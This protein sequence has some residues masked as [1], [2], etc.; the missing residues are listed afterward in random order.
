MISVCCARM[1]TS[2][3]FPSSPHC[4]PS[5]VTTCPS[6]SYLPAATDSRTARPRE[7]RRTTVCARLCG[8]MR[9]PR[10]WT[11]GALA[12][13]ATVGRVASIF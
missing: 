13:R 4:D 1:S 9:A 10:S 8:G 12:P 11:A 5:T 2:L 6:P 3:P 7:L